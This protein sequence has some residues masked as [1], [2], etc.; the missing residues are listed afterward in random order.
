LSIRWF[1]GGEP[2]RHALGAR[3]QPG[4]WLLCDPNYWLLRFD[5][6]QEFIDSLTSLLDGR[7]IAPHIP[8]GPYP[9]L[10]GTIYYVH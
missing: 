4:E 9:V 6:Q 10:S 7:G 3:A 8:D 5:Q 1:E 2:G